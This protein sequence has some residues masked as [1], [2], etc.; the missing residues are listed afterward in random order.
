MGLK[1]RRFTMIALVS[2]VN[3]PQKGKDGGVYQ[4][5]EMITKPGNVWCF[6]YAS[7]EN[8]NWERWEKVIDAPHG[9]YVSNIRWKDETNRV[10][11]ADSPVIFN[12]KKYEKRTPIDQLTLGF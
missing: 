1:I 11:D 3:P 4:K 7:P 6:T 8:F 9:I 12:N 5:I 10:I 2:K